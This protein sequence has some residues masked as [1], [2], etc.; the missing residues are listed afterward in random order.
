[1][2]LAF[3]FFFS[4]IPLYAVDH[5]Q[6]PDL[7]DR[8]EAL[9]RAQKERRPP[10]ER[11]W[12]A[13]GGICSNLP[14]H[15]FDRPLPRWPTFALDLRERHRD[16]PEKSKVWIDHDFLDD[17]RRSIITEWWTRLKH[18][19]Q[20]VGERLSVRQSATHAMSFLQAVF[21]TMGRLAGQR[22]VAPGRLARSRRARGPRCG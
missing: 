13:D 16:L 15:F 7:S 2:S 12:F 10:V 17:K 18:E 22:A 14:V 6:Y 9:A 20:Q 3:P 4:S 1:M 5:T 8:A 21:D 11:C 19:P